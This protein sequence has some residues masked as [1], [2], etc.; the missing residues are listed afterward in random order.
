MRTTKTNE[1]DIF[2]Y[3][4]AQ[5]QEDNNIAKSKCKRFVCGQVYIGAVSKPFT[6][7]IKESDLPAMQN[8]YPDMRIITSGKKAS[9][10]YT[11][12]TTTL[13]I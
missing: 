8:K 11:K 4:D 9:I 5:L 3:S 6:K 2:V 1:N 7:I 13:D 10:K 12:P